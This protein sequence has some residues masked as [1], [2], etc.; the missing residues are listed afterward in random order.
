MKK[1]MGIVGFGRFGRLA[2]THLK[3]HFELLVYD[4]TDCDN[5]ARR[6]GVSP[7]PLRIVAARSVVLLCVPISQMESV[8]NEI[9]PYLIKGTL[10]VD[11]CSVKE[12]PVSLMKTI[13]PSHVD[14]L[15]AHP[16]FG[17]D[18]AVQG[19]HGKKVVLCAVRTRKLQRVIR[20][21]EGLKLRVLVSSPEAHDRGMAST[22]AIVQFL[23]RAFLDMGL[24][25][26]AT[27][28]PGYD[29]LIRIL[30]VVQNDTSEL[31]YDLQSLNRFAGGMRQRLIDSLALIDQR[32]RETPSARLQGEPEERDD[33]SRISGRTGRL[34]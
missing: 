20:F 15:G 13:L 8:L 18:S 23:G 12:Y 21:L 19:L 2:A 33:E 22:Q 17:P 28:T 5:A 7:G 30:E 27:A 26:E 1:T 6:L 34:Q 4:R 29:R 24:I 32:I 9:T 11:T 10:V 25:H 3:D 31:F 16:L 14:I